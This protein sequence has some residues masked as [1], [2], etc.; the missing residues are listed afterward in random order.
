MCL[1]SL[2]HGEEPVFD[3]LH[4]GSV[5]WVLVPTFPDQVK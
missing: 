4:V 5:G 2:V 3:G 1:L